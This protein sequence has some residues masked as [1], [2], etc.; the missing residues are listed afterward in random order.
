MPGF[1]SPN[2]TQVPN[3]LF[4]RLGEFDKSD[5]KVLLV[6]IR[7]TFGYH[8][9]RAEISTR[10]MADI[11][12]LSISSIKPAADKL[13]SMGLI[14]KITDGQKSIT[15]RAVV[16]SDSMIGTRKRKGVSTIGTAAIQPSVQGVSTIESQSGLNKDKEKEINKNKNI[17]QLYTENIGELTAMMRD[18]LVDA[19][20]EFPQEWFEPAFLEAVKSNVRRWNYVRRILENWKT[21]GVGWRPGGKQDDRPTKTQPE[22][23]YQDEPDPLEGKRMSASEYKAW[24]AA[25]NGK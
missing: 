18:E 17:Y 15:W 6:I 12:G 5:L 1:E 16:A 22:P 21:N 9:D 3:D 14:E 23:V 10:E 4:D 11:T 25:Q 19:E 8:R 20:K 2:Y 7:N 13:E 24:K